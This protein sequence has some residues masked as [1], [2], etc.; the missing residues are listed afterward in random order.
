M[1]NV[2]II[3]LD[4][5]FRQRDAE[6]YAGVF[7]LLQQRLVEQR[8]IVRVIVFV[9]TLC[10]LSKANNLFIVDEELDKQLELLFFRI[11]KCLGQLVLRKKCLVICYGCVEIRNLRSSAARMRSDDS[12]H[13]TC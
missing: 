13:H 7:K 5:L 8:I 3:F 12:H 2:F 4:G 6:F 11:C 9:L 10:V 1:R